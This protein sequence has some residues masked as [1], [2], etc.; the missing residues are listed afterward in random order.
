MQVCIFLMHS[1][2]HLPPR[3]ALVGY[4]HSFKAGLKTSFIKAGVSPAG[5]IS[6]Q[7]ALLCAFKL[8]PPG[9]K[10]AGLSKSIKVGIRLGFHLRGVCLN[11]D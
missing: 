6:G 4:A 7:D 1:L 9:E 11:E 5:L 8:K 10:P 2:S 3:E